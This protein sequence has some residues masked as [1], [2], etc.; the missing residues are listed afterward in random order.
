[1]SD[2]FL[3]AASS[4]AAE[5]MPASADD[6]LAGGLAGLSLSGGG[7]VDAPGFWVKEAGAP[8]LRRNARFLTP[9][10]IPAALR[11]RLSTW[12][13][14]CGITSHAPLVT[15]GVCEDEGALRIFLRDAERTF[16][17][18]GHRVAFMDMLKRVWPENR[19]YHQGLGYVC[20][21][22][23]RMPQS[24]CS[25]HPYFIPTPPCLP[26]PVADA[27]VRLDHDTEHLAQADPRAQVYAR[28]LAWS[29]RGLRA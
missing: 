26:T 16:Q 27:F 29:S 19:D 9:D 20:S 28:V 4:R 23:V 3:E 12:P 10:G 18:E 13:A 8:L 17:D 22:L 6:A 1:M 15:D 14:L 7:L 5:A 25:L 24:G 2:S 11:E 21:L